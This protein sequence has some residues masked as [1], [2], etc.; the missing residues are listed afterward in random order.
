[1]KAKYSGA[2]LIDGV[3]A[4]VQC[5]KGYLF[6]IFPER[7]KT[8]AYC[9]CDVDAV[10]KWKFSKGDV[11]CVEC[12][13]RQLQ[14]KEGRAVDIINEW[15]TGI[16]IVWRVSPY[17]VS[18]NGWSVALQITSPLE[19]DNFIIHSGALDLVGVSNNR[20]YFTFTPKTSAPMWDATSQASKI[21]IAV[22]FENVTSNDKENIQN[23]WNYYYKFPSG[24]QSCA[25]DR[26]DCY[27]LKT[28][29][30]S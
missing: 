8:A 17:K 2:D 14:G 20:E 10:C 24:D 28:G 26:F 15:D 30:S 1:M 21:Y 19:S 7:V 5:T 6:N 9:R 4:S 13:T 18:S 29:L 11:M 3:Q 12:Q 27:P 22:Q 16:L 25:V 23:A